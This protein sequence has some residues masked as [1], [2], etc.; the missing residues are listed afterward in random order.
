MTVNNFKLK[1]IATYRPPIRN[2]DTWPTHKARDR[3]RRRRKGKK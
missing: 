2:G 1:L 3:R